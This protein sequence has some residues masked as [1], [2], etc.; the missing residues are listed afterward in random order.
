[1][2]PLVLLV[3]TVVGGVVLYWTAVA[4]GNLLLMWRARDHKPRDHPEAARRTVRRV[5]ERGADTLTVDG[6]GSTTPTQ[7]VSGT[8]NDTTETATTSGSSTPGFPGEDMDDEEVEEW[9]REWGLS[10]YE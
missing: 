9:L 6:S 3:G 1:M 5:Q 2:N 8:W 7:T 4:L 10:G